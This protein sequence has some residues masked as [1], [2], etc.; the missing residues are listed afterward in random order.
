MQ[1]MVSLLIKN[2]RKVTLLWNTEVISLQVRKLLEGKLN[3]KLRTWAALCI[4][5]Y[6]KEKQCG[7][8]NFILQ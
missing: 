7:K 6:I 5:L 3:M 4:I 8:H 1:D 2:S